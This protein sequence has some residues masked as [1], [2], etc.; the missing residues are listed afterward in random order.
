MEFFIGSLFTLG[1]IYLT[2]KVLLGAQKT[3]KIKLL[4]TQAKNFEIVKPA[5]LLMPFLSMKPL[6]S[7]ASKHYQGQKVPVA[8][9][10]DK[11]YWV[12]QNSVF[13]ADL[14]DGHINIES[15]KRVDM[16]GLSKV[17]LNKMM[18]IID[19]LA[20]ENGNDSSG[21]GYSQF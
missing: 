21:A 9:V 3:N 20:K 18:S 10:E 12:D 17:E 2:R 15:Q 16:M 19:Q 4:V 13:E 11:A 7:Q 5:V 14:V 6:V 1:C 8:I